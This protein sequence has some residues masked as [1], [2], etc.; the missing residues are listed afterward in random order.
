MGEHLT[1]AYKQSKARSD[2]LE[3]LIKSGVPAGHFGWYEKNGKKVPIQRD[4]VPFKDVKC[5]QCGADAKFPFEYDGDLVCSYLCGRALHPD[6]PN[7]PRDP[8]EWKR[9]E[10]AAAATKAYK[11]AL[12][13][14]KGLGL[15][16]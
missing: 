1:E 6:H 11:E 4:N 10:K 2:E 5:A 3:A 16:V 9:L 7:L 15:G 14:A 13:A 12:A 8:A